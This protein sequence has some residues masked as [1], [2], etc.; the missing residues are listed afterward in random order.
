VDDVTVTDA[1]PFRMESF[2]G[3]KKT[4][5]TSLKDCL[6]RREQEMKYWLAIEMPTSTSLGVALAEQSD[7]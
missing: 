1:D 4:L 2:G 5:L 6:R 7:S 3:F